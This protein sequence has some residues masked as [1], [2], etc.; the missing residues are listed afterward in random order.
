M[1]TAHTSTLPIKDNHVRVQVRTLPPPIPVHP[2][3]IQMEIRTELY[4]KDVNWIATPAEMTR[5]RNY[6][7]TRRLGNRCRGLGEEAMVPL[8]IIDRE[9][10][11][12]PIWLSG[13]AAFAEG[14]LT[15]TGLLMTSLL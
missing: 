8:G 10:Q 13:I 6:T 9:G 2:T 11:S 12:A 15:L 5:K 3:A 1:Y 14:L 4:T 7:S